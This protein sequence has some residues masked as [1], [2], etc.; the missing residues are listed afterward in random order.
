MNIKL[1]VL[2]AKQ[3]KFYV[4]AREEYM[5]RLARYCKLSVKEYKTLDKL[6]KDVGNDERVYY[7]STKGNLMSSEELA[8]R[9]SD[10]ETGGIS[11]VTAVIAEGFEEAFPGNFNNVGISKMDMSAELMSVVALEQIYR[12]YKIINGETYHK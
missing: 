2:S 11:R 8:K 4:S 5:K 6:L 12:A 10:M 9:I 1:Y 7:I 3:E